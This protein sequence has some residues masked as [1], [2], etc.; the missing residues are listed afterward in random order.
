MMLALMLHVHDYTPPAVSRVIPNHIKGHE[1]HKLGPLFVPAEYEFLFLHAMRGLSRLLHTTFEAICTEFADKW[2]TYTVDTCSHLNEN[3]FYFAFVDFGDREISLR[4]R[5]FFMG[6][7]SF[8]VTACPHLAD[9]RAR[10]SSLSKV[11]EWMFRGGAV[12]RRD[13]VDHSE[14]HIFA[15]DPHMLRLRRKR[16]DEFATV[17]RQ[18]VRGPWNGRIPE[19]MRLIGER[20]GFPLAA[21]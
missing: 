17:H 16:G 10:L 4:W 20:L 8:S 14:L 5:P 9:V 15:S 2:T 1:T 6:M 12:M 18:R 3:S 19:K 13:F 11:T 7:S 21:E